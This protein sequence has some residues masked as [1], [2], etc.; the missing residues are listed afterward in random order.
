VKPATFAY[1][2]P[3]TLDEA[4]RVLAENGSEAKPLAGGQS[5]IPAMNFR[6]ARPAVL[7]DLN[8]VGELGYVDDGRTVGRSDGQLHIGAMTRQCVAERHEMI[9]SMA[10]LLKETMPFIAHPQIRNRGTIGGSLAHA[11][12]AA[13][14]P[15]VMVA[16][17]ATFTVRGAHG[18]RAIPATD[19]YTG[20]FVTALRPGE[21]L[22]DIAIPPPKARSGW[23]FIEVA[24]RHGDYALAGAAVVVTLDEKGKCK[25]ARIALVSVGDVPMLAKKAIKALIG[26]KPTPEVIKEAAE[27]AGAKDCD[28]PGDIHASAAYRR[29]LTTVLT[30]RAL[31]TAFERIHPH[32]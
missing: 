6:L 25:E 27:A 24:R 23:A 20:L 28:P 18:S 19:F 3:S 21:L 11:D 32:P 10:P 4:I 9:A 12:P 13:E 1:H 22:V 8:R 16:L 5:L 15:S 29:Q 2:R 7:V 14:L 26:E 17:D 30:R 31:T